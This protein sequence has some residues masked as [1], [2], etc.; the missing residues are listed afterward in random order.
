MRAPAGPDPDGRWNHNVHHHGLLLANV[1]EGCRA[2][3]DVGCG[4]GLLTRALAGRSERVVGIDVDPDSVARARAETEGLPNVEVVEGDVMTHP[5]APAS[6][7]AVLSVATLHHLD[8]EDGLRRLAEL[9]APG[10]VL[11]VVGLARSRSGWDL[12]HDAVGAVATR[13]HRRRHGWW[14]HGATVADPRETYTQALRAAA[15]LLPGCR[16]RR[17]P[18]F[19]YSLIWTKPAAATPP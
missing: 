17:H 3:L 12:A 4:D 1:P 14:D 11:G 15:L 13:I 5:L 9:V 8:L 18:L 7:D 2:A 16:Y 19:R 10:G 6:F